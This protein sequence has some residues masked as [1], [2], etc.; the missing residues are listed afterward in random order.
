MSPLLFV[1]TLEPLLSY[2]RRDPDCSGVKI[3]Y[4]EHKAVAIA[5]DILFFIT[6]P[7]ITIPNILKNLKNFG[8]VSNFKI[9]PGKSEVLNLNVRKEE[10]DSL[11]GAFPFPWRR[12]ISY[13]GVKLSNNL[14]D[15]Y[16]NNYIPLLDEIRREVG[17]L[18][19]RPLSWF[20]RINVVK[21]TIMPKILYKFQMLPIPLPQLFFRALKGILSRFVWGGKKPRIASSV[22][23]R[24]KEKGGLSL[25]DFYKY[26]KAVV[27]SQ[28]IERTKGGQKGDG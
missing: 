7:R 19:Y 10:E 2:I 22:L 12:T 9:N 26:Y 20:G 1:L 28:V 14:K 11:A 3:G 21:M 4:A 18:F 6:N 17:G 8:E 13:L 27:L 5:D 24:R 15:L 25:P 16:L 23:S